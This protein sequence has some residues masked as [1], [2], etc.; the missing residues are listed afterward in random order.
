MDEYEYGKKRA[1][2]LIASW[3]LRHG[4]SP[5]EV[6]LRIRATL[7]ARNLFNDID[8]QMERGLVDQFRSQLPKGDE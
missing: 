3:R 4:L 2:E 7:D 6:T 5:K 8:P 1:M